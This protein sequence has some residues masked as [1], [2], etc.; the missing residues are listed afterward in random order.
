M[1]VPAR[2]EATHSASEIAFALKEADCRS[3]PVFGCFY[4]GSAAADA[5]RLPT[6]GRRSVMQ[7]R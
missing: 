1:L 7:T 2:G 6:P 3:L 5:T 4:R